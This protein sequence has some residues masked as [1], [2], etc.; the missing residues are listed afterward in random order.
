VFSIVGKVDAATYEQ[1]KGLSRQKS[2]EQRQLME[3]SLLADRF[4]L[5]MHTEMQD[6]PVY[7]LTVAKAGKL[8]AA[9]D[10]TGSFRFNPFPSN[11]APESITRG[12]VVNRVGGHL[13]LTA[14]GMS[15]EDLVN[16]LAAQK[17]TNGEHIVNQTGLTGA[18]DFTLIWGPPDNAGTAESDAADEPPLFVALQQQLGLKLTQAKAPAEVVVIDHIEKPVFDSA[19]VMSQSPAARVVNVAL[20]KTNASTAQPNRVATGDWARDA[21]GKAEFDVASVR[22][23]KSEDK[24]SSNVPLGSGNVFGPTGGF[25]VAKGFTVLYYLEF[26][27]KLADYQ[28]EAFQKAAPGWVSTDRFDIEAR[29]GVTNVTKDQLRLMMQSLLADRFKLTAHYVTREDSVYGLVP[30]RAGVTGPKLQPHPE[31]TPCWGY[32]AGAPTATDGMRAEKIPE[33]VAKGFPSVCN[34]IIGVPA[35]AVDRYSFGARNVPM[36]LIASVLSSWGN[37]GRPVIDQTGL[38]GT[39]DF[40]LEFTP[41][42]PPKYARGIDSGGPTFEEALQKQL[43]LKLVSQRGSVEFLQLDHVERPSEN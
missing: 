39:Y 6:Q 31:G 20:D 35:S 11:A 14:K 22:Q 27:Y 8:T 41:Q 43:G 7:A 2:H 23:N 37:L 10:A 33:T 38:G 16:A 3:Q 42:P 1:N 21:G 30:I 36:S 40:V 13:K 24:P 32:F 18:Y 9:K 12:L 4:K 17:E 26:A 25:L 28:A 34:G 19:E 5:K 15:I 29:T